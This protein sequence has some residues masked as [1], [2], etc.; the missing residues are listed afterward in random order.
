MRLLTDSE[1]SVVLKQL[2]MLQR[3]NTELKELA[4]RVVWYDWSDNDA[5]AVEAIEQLRRYLYK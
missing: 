3:E 2:E 5:D 4:R 1:F